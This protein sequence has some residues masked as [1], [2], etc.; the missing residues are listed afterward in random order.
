MFKTVYLNLL[1]IIHKL[2]ISTKSFKIKYAT[3]AL[4]TYR[5]LLQNATHMKQ[6]VE[7]TWQNL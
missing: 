7:W 2:H 4:L 1:I 5:K 3:T 6:L